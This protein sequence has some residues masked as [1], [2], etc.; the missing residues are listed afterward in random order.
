MVL[1][2]PL[3]KHLLFNQ[4]AVATVLRLR[5]QNSRIVNRTINIEGKTIIL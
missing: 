2:H 1:S 3:L 4:W 5:T